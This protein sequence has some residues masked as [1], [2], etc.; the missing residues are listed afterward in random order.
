MLA[1]GAAAAES[2]FNLLGKRLPATIGPRLAS[3][4]VMAM[5][6]LILGALSIASGEKI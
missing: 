6:L 2:G 1:L 5:A 3:A 4:V